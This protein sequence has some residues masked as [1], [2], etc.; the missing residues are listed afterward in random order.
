MKNGKFENWPESGNLRMFVEDREKQFLLE[1]ATLSMH[2]IR[3][4]P[5]EQLKSDYRLNFAVDVDRILHSLA[6]SRYIDKTQVFYL[7][8]NDHITHRMLHVQLVSKVARTIGRYLC[9]NEDLIEAIAIG[10]D[11]GHS[12]F[13]HDGEKFLTALCQAH[14]IGEFHHN[15]QS[16]EFLERVER[17]G[18]GLN[19]C[20]QTIDGILC[21]DGEVNDTKLTPQ[22]G[23]TFADHERELALRR[24]GDPMPLIPMTL[25][26]CV[27]RFA[28]S[29]SYVGRD[30][31]DAIRLG[32]IKREDLPGICVKKLGRTNGTMVYSLVTDVIKHSAGKPYVS[33]SKEVSEALVVLKNFNYE[34][35]YTNPTFKADLEIIENMFSHLFK[36]YMTDIQ[37]KNDDSPI[38]GSFINSMSEEYLSVHKPAHIVRDFVSGMTD[39]YFLDQV[40]ESQRPKVKIKPV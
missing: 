40:P 39:Q 23:K 16:V 19:L 13:G 5:E 3:R 33:F 32:L 21:H 26:G 2:G 12:P 20:L 38:Y 7:V 30:V 31:E 27:V 8:R 10:H 11:I 36:R 9:L 28:D 29:I 34:R 4:K 14:G 15:V 25:E 37:D 17:K 6:Y 18:I 22:R 35:I 1:T 24:S